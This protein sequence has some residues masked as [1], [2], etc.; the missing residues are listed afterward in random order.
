MLIRDVRGYT[1]TPRGLERFEAL[2]F[3]QQ[4]RVVA[5][6]DAA[7][8]AADDELPGIDGQGRA[9]LPGLI[10]AHA[11]LLNLGR[12]SLEVDLTGAASVGE[13]ARRVAAFADA[14]PDAAWVLGRGWNQELWPE[15][16]FPNATQLDEVLA[17]RPA[18]LTRV[19]GHAA[20]VNSRAMSLAGVDA[21][22]AV[23]AGGDLLRTADGTP[24]GVFIDAA[25]EL[26]A[27]HIPAP[28]AADDEVALLLA[29]G[30][31]ASVGLTGVHDAGVSAQQ[32]ALYRKLADEGRLTLRVYAMLS[33]GE[34]RAFDAPIV[35][36]GDGRLSVR[37]VKL[38]ADGSLGSRGA[39]LLAPYSDAPDTRGLLFNDDARMRSL[40]ADI[41]ARGFQA[42]V[43]AIGDA[44][45]RQV[46]KAF[47]AVQGGKPSPLRNRI[48]HA[49]VVAVEDIPR[50][51]DLGLIASM[52]FTHATSD[53]NM[54][55]ARIGSKRI[56]G[57]YAWQRFLGQGTVLAGG[58]DFPVEDPNPFFGLHAA[59]TR[60]DRDGLPEAGWHTAQALTLAEALRA[61]T[62]DAAWAAHQERDLGS[63]EPGKRADFVLLDRDP[64]ETPAQELWQI[65]V[66]ETWL[67]GERVYTAATTTAGP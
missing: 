36:Y 27:S 45:N 26:V 19:D 33:A 16:A 54:A 17:G 1:W 53:K 37:S 10:D 43:H 11:H 62:L 42:S 30:K 4:G 58:S 46:L 2:R 29:L 64:F 38:Y 48:E 59:V 32:V 14:H 49:Q 23:P 15:R 35:S 66:L 44:A 52:Q 60:R 41:N 40:I 65:R 6:G 61:F 51:R 25:M 21:G 50:F 9:L 8:I 56:R 18:F 20:W 57:A 24:S 39:A 55:E 67:D 34:E 5:V 7:E 12:A 22:T 63:L 47:A 28:T 3:T 13:A 31:A